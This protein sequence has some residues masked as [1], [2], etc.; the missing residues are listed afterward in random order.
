RTLPPLV[1]LLCDSR[2][3]GA[4]TVTVSRRDLRTPRIDDLLQREEIKPDPEETRRLVADQVVLVT[5]AGRRIG[6]DVCRQLE[7]AGTRK[8]LLLDKSENGLFFANLEAAEAAGREN[9]KP[10]LID[11]L[12]RERVRAIFRDELPSIVFHAA[13]H[14]HVALMELHPRE[15]IRNN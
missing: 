14:K 6:A 11:L 3:G 7:A 12:D 10:L 13:A 4:S 9:V 15:A 5:G 2:T 8:L 1:A